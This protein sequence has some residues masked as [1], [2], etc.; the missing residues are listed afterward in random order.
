MVVDKEGYQEI[1]FFTK[2]CINEH[3]T[4]RNKLLETI[5]RP[6][7]YPRWSPTGKWCVVLYYG[8]RKKKRQF[9]HDLVAKLYVPNPKPLWLTKVAF[10]NGDRNNY[11]PSN[12]EWIR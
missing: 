1:P 5:I 7:L 8:P 9:L 4:V 2:Y 12:L 3:G 10:K 11:D 6:A